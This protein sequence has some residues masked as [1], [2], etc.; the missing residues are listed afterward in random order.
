MKAL[1]ILILLLPSEFFFS[2]LF[3]LSHC[4]WGVLL[5]SMH[6]NFQNIWVY[7]HSYTE[8]LFLFGY[9]VTKNRFLLCW[10]M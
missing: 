6:N 4:E 9:V 10:S 1:A 7:H 8:M 2:N 5:C 3:I